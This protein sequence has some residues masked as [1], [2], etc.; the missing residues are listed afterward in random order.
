MAGKQDRRWLDVHITFTAPAPSGP[1]VVPV[2]A[3]MGSKD[4]PGSL[5]TLAPQES[6]TLR[7]QASLSE[8]SKWRNAGLDAAKV[9][10][11]ANVTESYFDGKENRIT[12]QSPTVRSKNE[13]EAFWHH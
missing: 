9:T 10:V 2:A 3:L 11:G 8:T 13:I 12:S 5:L 4:V 7:V 1:V 6:V